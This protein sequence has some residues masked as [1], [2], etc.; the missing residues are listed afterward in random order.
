MPP[1]CTSD[2]YQPQ[3]DLECFI[4][5]THHIGIQVRHL[6]LQPSLI[7]GPNLFQQYDRVFF[8]LK[9]LRR[10]LHMRR[11]LSFRNLRSNRRNDH[12]RTVAIAD[13]ILHN[14]HWS[15]STLLGADNRA[16]V[17]IENIPSPNRHQLLPSI[18]SM[19][20]EKHST[21]TTGA[22]SARP[23]LIAAISS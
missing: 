8:E 1:L 17:C 18:H 4:Y 5:L 6:F 15:V 12:G 7:N 10:H 11:Q 14:Q 16:Q 9:A 13:I 23:R 2:G 19:D 20:N 22:S 3:T 21:S